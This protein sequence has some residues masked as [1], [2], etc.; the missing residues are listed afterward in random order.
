MTIMRELLLNT[1][2]DLKVNPHAQDKINMVKESC[3]LKCKGN[4]QII[5]KKG[6]RML[7]GIRQLLMVNQ[8]RLRNYVGF[9]QIGRHLDCLFM[10]KEAVDLNKVQQKDPEETKDQVLPENQADFPPQE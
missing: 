4:K 10:T 1:V 7:R 8:S 3:V 5:M 6:E 9:T 2:H